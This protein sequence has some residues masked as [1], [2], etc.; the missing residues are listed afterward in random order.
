[1]NKR[2]EADT[3]MKCGRLPEACRRYGLGR[4][5][6]RSLAQAASAEIKLGRSYLINFEKVDA[7]M[8]SLS[9]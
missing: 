9:H 7:Y 1:M 2:P 5:A 8:D 3:S 4:N 6:M